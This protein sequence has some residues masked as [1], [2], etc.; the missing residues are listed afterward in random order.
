M[1]GPTER[2][3]MKV[4]HKGPMFLQLN[5]ATTLRSA[6]IERPKRLRNAKRRLGQNANGCRLPLKN[7]GV[8]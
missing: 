8:V 1:R 6:K 5:K 2:F 7:P 3:R 4:G